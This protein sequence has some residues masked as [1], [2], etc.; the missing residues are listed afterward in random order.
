[1]TFNCFSRERRF[2][3]F[4]IIYLF[5]FFSTLREIAIARGRKLCAMGIMQ[6]Q[7]ERGKRI[8]IGKE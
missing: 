2:L 6:L 5:S 1:M 8:M 3:K 7:T 4:S